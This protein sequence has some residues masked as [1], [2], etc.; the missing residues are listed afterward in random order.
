M[1]TR[2]EVLR[3]AG[4]APVLGGCSDKAPVHVL[5]FGLATPPTTLDPRLATDAASERI[6]RLLYSAL[7]QL[8]SSRRPQPDLAR[9]QVLSPRRFR[10]E[11]LAQRPT[12]WGGNQPS[13]GDV[14]ATYR[15]LRDPALLS[16][17]ASSLAQIDRI[18]VLDHARLEFHLSR[19]D[20]GFVARTTMGIVPASAI[21][22][23][24]NLARIPQGSGPLRFV[25]WDADQ[26]LHL[27]RRHDGLPVQFMAVP[28]PTMRVLKLLHN[29]LDLIQND[30]PPELL[31][32][33]NGRAE[34]HGARCAGTTFTYLGL[35]LRDPVLADR[36]VRQA[37]AHAI[38]RSAITRYLLAGYAHS[39]ETI[40]TPTHW[41]SPSGL[42]PHRYD[43]EHAAALLQAAGYSPGSPLRLSYKTSTD[44][45]RLR[46]ASVI[47]VQLAAVGIEVAIQSYDWG[48]FFGDIKSGRFQLYSLSWVGV[49]N[50]D[51]FRY[52]LH[53]QSRPP[54]GANRGGYVST[55]MDALIERA[56]RSEEP[57]AL[58]LY[59][60]IQNR[61]HAE[62]V[63]IPLWYEDNYALMSRR[64]RGYRPSTDGDYAALKEASIDVG[65]I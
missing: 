20:P 14:A 28:D 61:M 7:V 10:F 26:Q 41:A 38:D 48:T 34:L 3:L 19:D 35:N 5:R 63:Y 21:A 42:V 60:E 32:Y 47:Q 29:E 9:W 58:T 12:F 31:A 36:R 40:L 6:N 57:L 15:S 2:R 37:I 56:E 27:Q 51:I 50:P 13:A 45:L 33:L 25:A 64:V 43:P 11:L 65:N 44:P 22:S 46:I 62:L 49:N 4:L 16:P 17:H 8:D 24:S 1:V 23:G 54:H 39:A 59:A 18:E 53:S 30:L 52:V 55:E